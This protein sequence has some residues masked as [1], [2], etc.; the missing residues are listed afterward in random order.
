MLLVR[1]DALLIFDFGLD[2]LSGVT[3]LIL[4]GGG[5]ACHGLHKDPHLCVH[6]ATTPEPLGHFTE[7]KESLSLSF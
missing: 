3:G 2:L 4:E 6:K 1:Q 7:E 5:L